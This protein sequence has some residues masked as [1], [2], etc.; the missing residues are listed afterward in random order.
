MIKKKEQKTLSKVGKEGTYLNIIKGIYDKP[1]VN[2]MF[3]GEK[4][5]AFPLKSHKDAHS[6]QFY[7]TNYW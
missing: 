2:V 7:S 3:S 5:N 6:H 1:K 4:M